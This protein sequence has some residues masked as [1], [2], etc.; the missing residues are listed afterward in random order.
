MDHTTF[1]RASLRLAASLLLAGQLL[2][3]LVT[4]FHTGGEANHHSA[5]F[6]LNLAWVIWLVVVA[7]RSTANASPARR[8]DTVGGA[9]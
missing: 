7:R 9:L 5:I 3:V 4:L 6:V 1:D 8:S 2:Y